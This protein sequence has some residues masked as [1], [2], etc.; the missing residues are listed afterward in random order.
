MIGSHAN[1]ESHQDLSMIMNCSMRQNLYNM[2]GR[3][4]GVTSL[5]PMGCLPAAVTLFGG[6][7][8]GCVA[9]LNKDSVTFN[10]KMNAAAQALKKSH[11]ELKLVVFDIYNPLLDLIDHPGKSGT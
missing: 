5:P 6:G 7:S 11:P 9:R 4:V 10:K 3:R 2:G 1:W 8:N